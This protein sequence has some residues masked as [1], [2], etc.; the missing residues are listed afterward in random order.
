VRIQGDTLGVFQ[1]LYKKLNHSDSALVFSIKRSTLSGRVCL[2]KSIFFSSIPLFHLSLFK[3]PIF[4]YDEI[5]KLQ[6]ISF[7]GRG[8]KKRKTA[9]IS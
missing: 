2:I 7:G 4:A 1:P 9:W 6:R 8:V 3:A 5:A